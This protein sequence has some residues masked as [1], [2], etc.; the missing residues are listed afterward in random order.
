MARKKSKLR[1][2][3]EFAAEAIPEAAS[4]MSKATYHTEQRRAKELKELKKLRDEQIKEKERELKFLQEQRKIEKK[5]YEKLGIKSSTTKKIEG[6]QKRLLRELTGLGGEETAYEIENSLKSPVEKAVEVAKNVNFK[7]LLKSLP[8]GL[9]EAGEGLMGL[10]ETFLPGE[11]SEF[12][13]KIKKGIRNAKEGY[14]D[15]AQ[16]E[17]R[18]GLG[19]KGGRILGEILTP[20]PGGKAKWLGKLGRALYAGSLWGGIEAGKK[21]YDSIE[22]ARKSSLNSALFG[23]GV[24]GLTH[25]VGAAASKMFGRKA[26]KAK[27]LQKIKEEASKAARPLT[28]EEV[29]VAA[30]YL[31]KG[32]TTGEVVGDPN[33]IEKI[34]KDTSFL[35]KRRIRKMKDNMNVYAKDFAESLPLKEK[36]KFY[37]DLVKLEE[38]A[39]EP[40]QKLYDFT[41]EEGIGLEGLL[42]KKKIEEWIKPVREA[43]KH[44]KGIPDLKVKGLSTEKYLKELEK[45][46][47]TAPSDH[48]AFKKFYVANDDIVPYADDFIKFR[49]KIKT[50]ADK[51]GVENKQALDVLND[52][53]KKL[54]EK[55]DP[56]KTLKAADK[57]YATVSSPFKEKSLEEAL[58]I[59]KFQ[60]GRSGAPSIHQVMGKQDKPHGLLFESMDLTNKKRII[61]SFVE[62]ELAEPGIT[63]PRAIKKAW[64]KMPEF[65][66][67]SEEQG[68]KEI[69][70]RMK[71]IAEKNKQLSG[72]QKSIDESIGSRAA[73]NKLLML[74]RF[75]PLGVA[76][77]GAKGAHMAHHAAYRNKTGVKHLEQYLNPELLEGARIKESGRYSRP[78]TKALI[79]EDSQ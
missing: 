14:E 28:D 78:L 37:E 7:D 25:G 43:I 15:W 34:T 73:I 16:I 52:S 39:L 23:A 54:E 27:E 65:I 9:M 49:K 67:E 61:G 40:A 35:N 46:L 79:Y 24:G 63:Y 56:K 77:A 32:S 2:I 71:V 44:T 13:G 59:G 29:K 75:S 38:K 45:R 10:G 11:G 60:E 58:E 48:D 21:D 8:S 1:H 36:I 5:G 20:T 64:E 18:E 66:K 12:S 74:L 68:L 19:A 30:E 69:L 70:M 6:E 4:G 47:F 31:G 41:K 26:S 57:S 72:M 3:L 76:E 17:D 50:L 62:K 42:N 33:A 22:E 53:L 55:W 51:S